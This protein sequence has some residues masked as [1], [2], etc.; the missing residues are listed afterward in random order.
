MAA[1]VSSGELKGC[2]IQE[3]LKADVSVIDINKIN[4]CVAL[5]VEVFMEKLKRLNCLIGAKSVFTSTP[6]GSRNAIL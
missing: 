5:V 4:H 2:E 6:G 3:S 1:A